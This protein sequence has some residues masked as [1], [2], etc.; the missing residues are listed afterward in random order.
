[1]IRIWGRQSS[2]NVQKVLWTCDE[3]GL[4]FARIEA[5]GAFSDLRTDAF[6]ALN[7]N[8]RIPVLEDA[9]LVLW[10]SN[11][12]V[13]YVAAA[14]GAGRLCPADPA[15]RADAERWMDWQ[16]TEVLPGMRTLFFQLVRARAEE[17]DAAAAQ[18]SLAAAGAAWR[19]LDAHL[20][21]RDFVA[22][23]ALSI[24]DIPLGTFAH[25]WMALP[26][27]RPRLPA[28]AAWYERLCARPAYARNVMRPL[29]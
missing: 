16:L 6:R 29:E 22:G 17:K 18:A 25:R 28:L 1:M 11:T 19:L 14:Y 27:E 15:A 10:E 4:P 5:G 23:T 7:P 24:A 2:V 8:A 26:I 9:G 13:R 12:I 21:G 20:R 3:L